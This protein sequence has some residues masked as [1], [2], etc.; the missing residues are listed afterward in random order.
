MVLG[1][2]GLSTFLL[3]CNFVGQRADQI[4]MAEHGIVGRGILLGEPQI[5]KTI[6]CFNELVELR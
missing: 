6:L 3:H 5:S 1:I 4:A 2:Q